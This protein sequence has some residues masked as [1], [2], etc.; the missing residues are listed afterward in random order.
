MVIRIFDL[1]GIQVRTSGKIGLSQFI[2]THTQGW[3][4][5]VLNT[6]KILSPNLN[7]NFIC[8]FNLGNQMKIVL[9]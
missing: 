9:R 4:E 6:Q 5:P 8:H 7:Q 1:R 2:N 3:F